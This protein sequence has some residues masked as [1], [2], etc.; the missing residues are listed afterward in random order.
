MENSIPFKPINLVF[1]FGL[2]LRVK[3]VGLI[4]VS[5]IITILSIPLDESKR[6]I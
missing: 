1:T 4:F 3:N 5:G 2:E 6:S